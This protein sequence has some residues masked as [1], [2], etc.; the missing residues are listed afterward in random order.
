MG[1][2]SY[3]EDILEQLNQNELL[4]DELIERPVTFEALEEGA[5][6]LR[7]MAHQVKDMITSLRTLLSLTGD[8]EQSL[9][10]R[11]WAAESE[12]NEKAMLCESLT[13]ENEVLTVRVR[14][15]QEGVRL[16]QQQLLTERQRKRQLELHILNMQKGQRQFTSKQKRKKAQKKTHKPKRHRTMAK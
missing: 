16:S 4:A 10:Q 9:A 15:Q 14:Q 1:W 6:T 12:L 2:V 7:L 11:C 8:P 13:A 5:K 3:R